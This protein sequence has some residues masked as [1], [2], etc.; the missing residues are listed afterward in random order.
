MIYTRFS[1]AQGG[2]RESQRNKREE[3]KKREREEGG[4]MNGCSR[5]ERPQGP[6]GG[7]SSSRVVE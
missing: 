4:C 2:E 3:E 5:Q 6:H 1:S 7:G